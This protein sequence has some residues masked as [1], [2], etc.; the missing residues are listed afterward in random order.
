M[1]GAPAIAPDAAMVLGLASTAMPFAGTPE[2][3][4]ERW[5]RVMRLHGEVGIALQALGVSEM[6]L[7]EHDAAA[8]HGS[9]GAGEGDAAGKAGDRDVIANVVDHASRIAEE[10]GAG[11][12]ATTDLL[13]GVMH[14]YGE[15]FDRVLHTHGTDREELLEQLARQEL[16]AD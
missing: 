5:L 15:D 13:M 7:P 3:E 6:S 16:R 2:A 8:E 9:P 4:A 10:R 12:V 11:G 1:N 14:V